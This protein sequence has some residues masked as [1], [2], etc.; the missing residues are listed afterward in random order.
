MDFKNL[1]N[2]RLK[3]LN[4]LCQIL[5]LFQ[6]KYHQFKQYKF[7]NYFIFILFIISEASQFYFV[8]N[9]NIKDFNLYNK[10]FLFI[11]VHNQNLLY[12]KNLFIYLL[13]EIIFFKFK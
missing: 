11:L 8:K 13:E 6:I 7:L 1:I 12:R 4:T 2:F 9:V 5:E 10:V 3:F